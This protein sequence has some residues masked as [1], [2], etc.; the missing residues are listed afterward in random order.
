[1]NEVH[2]NE[3]MPIGAVITSRKIA[4]S[5]NCLDD[6]RYMC[7]PVTAVVGQAVLNIMEKEQ[8]QL[9]ALTMGR[10][11]VDRL[12]Q[13]QRIHPN[14]GQVRGIGLM[15]GVDIVWCQESRRPAPE[16]AEKISYR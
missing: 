1:M 12:T 5:L 16:L 4:E 8:C 10:L 14:I 7:D 9:N 11:L 15:V 2:N 13:L 6:N 3:S